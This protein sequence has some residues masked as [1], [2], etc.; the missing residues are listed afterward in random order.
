MSKLFKKLLSA[1]FKE[2]KFRKHRI[3]WYGHK[4][5]EELTELPLSINDSSIPMVCLSK[6]KVYAIQYSYAGSYI[7][8]LYKVELIEDANL[9]NLHYEKDAKIFKE[10]FPEFSEEIFTTLKT[11]DWMDYHQKFVGLNLDIVKRKRDILI[12]KVYELGFDGFF[13]YEV[14]KPKYPSI[15]LFDNKKLKILEVFNQKEILEIEKEAREQRE[16][17][18]GLLKLSEQEQ[19]T[20]NY[21]YIINQLKNGTWIPYIGDE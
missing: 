14:S 20:R 21:P 1:S 16:R 4:G 17:L 2:A 18:E 15:A 19:Q 12:K 6:N 13:N 7:G 9:L 11:S 10:A 8:H 5:K 3:Y